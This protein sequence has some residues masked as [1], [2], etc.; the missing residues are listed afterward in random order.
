MADRM[1][2]ALKVADG[3]DERHSMRRRLSTWLKASR[4]TILGG[5]A[6]ILVF[7]VWQM[8]AT[9][10]WVDTDFLPPPTAVMASVIDVVT[11]EGFLHDLSVSGYEFSWGLGISVLIGGILGI[12]TGWY[13]PFEEFLQPIVIGIN[14]IPNLALIPVL[15]LIFGIGSFPKI[16]LVVF[17]CIVVMMM[18]TAAGVKSVDPQ[19]MRMSRSFKARE[20]QLIRTVVVPFVVPY[21]MTGVR[22][23]V[24]RAVVTV[25]VAEIFGSTAGLGNM[26]I[27]AQG[28]FNMPVMYASIVILTT[29]GILLTQA[30]AAL[31]HL[32]VRWRD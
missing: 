16:L 1:I 13:R 29:I 27:R 17:A 23:C 15:I 22:I 21:F 5:L 3:Q 9:Y 11:S 26:L 20:D 6:I 7:L 2:A 10:Q 14:S 25:A 30:A 8:S 19:L 32:F 18:N 12:L 31:E 24:G 28:Q 4:S